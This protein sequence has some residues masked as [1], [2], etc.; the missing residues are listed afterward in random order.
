[1]SFVSNAFLG[2]THSNAYY[3]TKEIFA[4]KGNPRS[5]DKLMNN[6][7]VYFFYDVRVRKSFRKPCASASDRC[8]ARAYLLV[9]IIWNMIVAQVVHKK[10]CEK[11]AYLAF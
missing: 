9:H 7:C 8:N 6:R 3:I 2:C 1:V 4:C 11:I 10:P 5:Y